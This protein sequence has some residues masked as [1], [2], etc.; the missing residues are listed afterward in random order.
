MRLPPPG[1]RDDEVAVDASPAPVFL[2]QPR[3]WLDLVL[4]PE[5]LQRGLRD[6]DAPGLPV[7]LHLVGRGDVVGPDVVLPLAQAEDPAEDAAG[8]DAHA[9]VQAH[10]RRLHHRAVCGGTERERERMRGAGVWYGTLLTYGSE[11]LHDFFFGFGVK[12]NSLPITSGFIPGL[13]GVLMIKNPTEPRITPDV[14]GRE[15][16]GTCMKGNRQTRCWWTAGNSIP[17][18]AF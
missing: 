1:G 11:V 4:A 16:G 10:V 15:G 7:G 3:P 5:V 9:H 6:V 2:P 14:I 12:P 8:V 13:L 18:G 17:K